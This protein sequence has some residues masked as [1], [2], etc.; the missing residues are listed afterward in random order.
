M[1]TLDYRKLDRVAPEPKTVLEPRPPRGVPLVSASGQPIMSQDGQRI[2]VTLETFLLERTGNPAFTA[3]EP[4]LEG[5]DAIEFVIAARNAIRSQIAKDDGLIVL[6]DEHMRRLVA[7][8]LK[9]KGGYNPEIQHSLLSC[10]LPA[11]T[12]HDGD[13]RAE[14][15]EKSSNGVGVS[16][17]TQA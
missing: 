7:A 1:K 11:R 10:V 14:L 17:E 5:I 12:V 16:S 13:L 4:V 6:E 3:L 8:T 15:A 9:P 2:V